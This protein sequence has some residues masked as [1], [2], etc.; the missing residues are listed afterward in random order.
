ML[1]AQQLSDT[2]RDP[3]SF[4]FSA[5]STS[6]SWFAFSYLAPH[7]PKIVAAAPDNASAFKLGRKEEELRGYEA[8]HFPLIRKA[9]LPSRRLGRSCWPKLDHMCTLSCKGCRESR[10]QCCSV[11]LG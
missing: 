3:C 4:R 1:L 5:P 7:D 8:H 6:M 2:L 10:R 9:K 11:A